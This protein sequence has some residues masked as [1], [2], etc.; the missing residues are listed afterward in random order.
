MKCARRDTR[1]AVVPIRFRKIASTLPSY[2]SSWNPTKALSPLRMTL[3][4]ANGGLFKAK[5]MTKFVVDRPD[6][7][8]TNI[9]PATTHPKDRPPEDHQHVRRRCR[10]RNPAVCN[11]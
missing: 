5:V 11:R 6:Y 4:V 1:A 8:G 10:L 7:F 2:P 3:Q 9:L